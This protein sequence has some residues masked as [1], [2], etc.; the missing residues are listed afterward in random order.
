MQ[1]QGWS[2]NQL[3]PGS[4]ETANTHWNLRYN[5][6]QHRSHP[7]KN[8][9]TRKNAVLPSSSTRIATGSLYPDMSYAISPKTQHPK[10]IMLP[11]TDNRPTWTGKPQ[12]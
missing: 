3:E 11:K 5:T 8:K 7:P 12:R 4:H 2:H 9:L 10:T 1:N 6:P